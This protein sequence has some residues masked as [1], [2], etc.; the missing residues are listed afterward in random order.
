MTVLF[1]GYYVG[2]KT[3]GSSGPVK[4]SGNKPAEADVYPGMYQGP[5][6]PQEAV[7]QFVSSG[8][9]LPGTSIPERLD[10]LKAYYANPSLEWDNGQPVGDGHAF[11]TVVRT[12]IADKVDSVT[13]EARRVCVYTKDFTTPAASLA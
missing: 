10:N 5:A 13:G 12:V 8:L 11:I 7:N 2:S 1:E 6:S 9:V 4:Y 3:D